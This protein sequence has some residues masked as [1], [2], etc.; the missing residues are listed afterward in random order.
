MDGECD[1]VD[2]IIGDDVRGASAVDSEFLADFLA[3]AREHLERIELD[4]LELENEPGNPEIVHS[5]F[6]SFHTLKGLA[7]FV[8]QTLVAKIAH[9]TETVLDDCRKKV[10][11]PERP[12]VESILRSA[13]L[14]QRICTQ[15]TLARDRAFLEEVALHV[16][17]LDRRDFPQQVR[18][19][20]AGEKPSQA[21]EIPPPSPKAGAEREGVPGG[22]EDVP[23][24]A[25][26]EEEDAVTEAV[27][28]E[29]V[30]A[31]AA[32][33]PAPSAAAP[34]AGRETPNKGGGENVRVS[35]AKVDSLVDMLGELLITQSQIEQEAVQRFGQNDPLVTH[36]G[37]LSRITK[38]LQGLSM[39]LSMV[40]L[41]STFQ[42]LRRLG[43]DTVA[44]LGKEV[45]LQ[46]FGEDTEIDRGVAERLLDPLV[47]LI[48]NAI[49]HG[50]EDRETRLARSKSPVGVVTVSAY[51]RRGSVFI[52][53]RDDGGG[54]DP[55]KVW[56]KAVER[57]LVDPGG[58]RNEDE[59]IGF[60]FLPGFST[61]A[62]VDG[63]SGR[64]VGMDVVKTEISR[65]GGRVDVQNTLGQGCAFVLKI[66]INMAI[67]NGTI[68]DLGGAHYILPTLTVKQIL[69]VTEDLWISVQGRDA[70]VRVRDR[71]IPVI[72]V[73]EIL[74]MKNSGGRRD[75]VRLVLVLELDNRVKAL[76]A[77]SVVGRQEIVV[78]PLNEAF[79]SLD[80]VSGASILGDGRVSLILDVEALFKY[81]GEVECRA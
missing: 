69:Q 23:A 4:V 76:P 9:R 62:T 21:P 72:P 18:L 6:R 52:E 65:I 56:R 45:D 1:L 27:A 11:L 12:V 28:A 13:D 57:G 73:E 68:V 7:G 29:I 49:S 55:E 16:D 8:G 81:G 30:P 63:V 59:I 46:F 74:G 32:P 24:T 5:L 64:G 42:K 60:L 19:I 79:R 54:I 70:M 78:K 43:R 61:A 41:K 37:R 47:H 53:V 38:E 15:M 50:V 36:L 48:K 26:W 31:A 66:P 20:P 22:E 3:E 75:D 44:S 34:V 14:L 58:I 77:R 40:S 80:F 33:V 67:L 10:L 2:L 39:S 71:L 25:S 51:S 17:H 35:T